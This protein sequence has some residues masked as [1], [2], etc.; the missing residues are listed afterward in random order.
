MRLWAYSLKIHIIFSKYNML[1][2]L[3]L[4][5]RLRKGYDIIIHS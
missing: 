5:L 3:L 2:S 4:T 1:K